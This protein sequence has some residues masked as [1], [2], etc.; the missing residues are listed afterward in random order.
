LKV[1]EEQ[2]GYKMDE[3]KKESSKGESQVNYR[4][5]SAKEFLKVKSSGE[6]DLEQSK[7]M[8]RQVA[9][10]VGP[11]GDYDLLM[12]LREAVGK[13]KAS[14]GELYQLLTVLIEHESAFSNKIAVL[15]RDDDQ[16]DKASFMEF[17]A[18]DR[19]R[20]RAFVSF[21]DATEWLSASG[22]VD[23]RPGEGC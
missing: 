18:E 19:F 14:Y 9:A 17:I 20:I 15:V 16:F 21:E 8:L 11:A 3:T 6:F 4:V 13:P 12:D 23:L 2:K 5:I 7:E 22:D 1:W 10:M